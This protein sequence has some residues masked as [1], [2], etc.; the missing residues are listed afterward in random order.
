MSA[1]TLRSA[2]LAAAARGDDAAAARGFAQAVA[3]FPGDAALLNSAGNFHAGAGRPADALALFDRA[4]ALDPALGEAA[5]NRAVVLT[6]LGRAGEA[7]AALTARQA[8][9][10]AIP[11]YWT[12][13]AAAETAG[14]DLRAA[15]ASHAEQLRRDPGNR[16]ALHGRAR[17]ALDRG[18]DGA[19]AWYD[20]ALA[21]TPGDPW[22]LHGLAQALEAAG[23]RA[24]ALALSAQLAG[25]L[26]Q[27]IDALELHAALRWAAG[28]RAEF[29][30]HY[31]AAVPHHADGAAERSW[32][33][34]LAGVDRHAAAAEILA[35]SRARIGARD[36]LLLDEAV[37]RGE[38]G[39][40]AGA[41]AIFAIAPPATPD[42][43]IAAARQALRTARPDV[44]EALLAQALGV[45]PD[46]VMAWSLRD[47]AWRVMDDPRHLWLHG[48]PVLV[49]ERLLDLSHDAH[50]A[51]VTMLDTLHDRAA[52]PIGQSVKLGSQTRGALFQRDEP[53]VR[54]VAQAVDRAIERYR[55]ALPDAHSAHPLL[56][57]RDA[58]WRVA[59]SWSIRLSGAGRHAPHVHPHG[60]LS[61]A[62]YFAVPAG[63]PGVLELGRP[64]AN[65]R[66]DLPPLRTIVPRVGHCVLFPSTLFHGTRPIA[67]GKRMTVAFDVGSR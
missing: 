22:L 36:P 26:P 52:M 30:D 45:R 63:D 23:D 17:T 28:D 34:M 59:G 19:V 66:L 51:A 39:D 7:A 16:R 13:R 12:T 42:W 47:L 6:R 48:D 55:H 8:T 60:L 29:C 54:A 27:W 41:A 61:S 20:A 1:A 35:R 5:I 3:A 46:D 53:A 33:A 58:P 2:A 31:A 14:G 9:L 15:A 32:A 43:Q 24:G 11:R 64:P 49:Q 38:A 25:Q 65:L 37:Y 57:S 67:T 10:A 62:A 44:A 4:L 56:R 18:D 21:V 50:A 40:D